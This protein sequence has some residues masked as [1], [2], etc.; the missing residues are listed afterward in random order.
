MS[1]NSGRLAIVI[2]AYKAEFLG[3][4]LECICAQT[5][6][7]FQLY[8]GDDCS[9]EPVGDVVQRYA[10]RRQ[11]HYVR[12]EENFGGKSLTRQWERCLALSREP[13]V[14][15]FS[16]DDVLEKNCVAALLAKLED[17]GGRCDVVRFDTL[18]INK[19]GKIDGL[20]PIHPDWEGWMEFSYFWLR[21]LRRCTMSDL[22][23]SRRA[24][25]ESGGF[26]EFPLAW[27]SDVAT[28]VR[29]AN[30]KGIFAVKGAKVLFRNS[31]KNIS[32]RQGQD[33]FR[34]K[35]NASMAFVQWL[36]TYACEHPD[37]SFPLS[38]GVLYSLS[39]SWFLDHLERHHE[40]VYGFSYAWAIAA[41]MTR[42]W[43]DTHWRNF[44]RVM[45]VNWS[46]VPDLLHRRRVGTVEQLLNRGT[47]EAGCRNILPIQ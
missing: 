14:W 24:F 20:N 18:S 5:C 9:P 17:L 7:D 35:I 42:F 41:F 28:L 30:R 10:A 43:G 45:K 29:L 21:G 46:V 36:R 1:L 16:D 31:G 2:P 15:L 26:V 34:M 4:A 22:V 6:Q 32:S 13:W 8:V 40:M 39:R 25:E 3:E 44:L 19:E 38:P 47:K 33:L 23:F 37:P 27:G 12:F 11:L